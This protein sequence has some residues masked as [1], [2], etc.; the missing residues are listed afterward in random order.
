[1]NGHV[2]IMLCATSRCEVG[3][4]VEFDMNAGCASGIPGQVPVFGANLRL[5]CHVHSNL[6]HC[7]W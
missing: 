5:A 7:R 6:K 3:T 2:Q 1:M 4:N